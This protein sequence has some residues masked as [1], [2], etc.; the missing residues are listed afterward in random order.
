MSTVLD[1]YA[2][3]QK[4]AAV[5]NPNRMA[6]AE[7]WRQDWVINVEEGTTVDDIQ[8]PDYWAH[9]AAHFQQFDRIEAR[10]ETGEWVAELIVKEVGRNWAAVHLITVHDLAASTDAPAASTMHK[11]MWRGA[12]HKWCVK[13]LADN[14]IL[15]ANMATSA[16]ADAWLRNYERVTSKT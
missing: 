14:E 8:K 3:G 12:Q 7:Q 15:Q 1:P 13:R 2:P 9:S 10:M 4:R 5:L 11:V 16:D 6:L